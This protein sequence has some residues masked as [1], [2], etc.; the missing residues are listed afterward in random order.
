MGF[1][2]LYLTEAD[3]SCNFV[4]GK[5]KGQMRAWSV[6][7]KEASVICRTRWLLIVGTGVRSWLLSVLVFNPAGSGPKRNR[8]VVG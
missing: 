8:H 1:S 6:F 5:I 2:P 4:H 7:A 3:P